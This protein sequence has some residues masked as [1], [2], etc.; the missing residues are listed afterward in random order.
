MDRHYRCRWVNFR[1]ASTLLRDRRQRRR[2]GGYR[3]VLHSRLAW[4]TCSLS[5]CYASYTK[6]MT[7]SAHSLGW[8]PI[9]TR[10]WRRCL[11]ATPTVV[12]VSR[13]K[14][15]RDASS[16]L[17]GRRT[18]RGWTP[19]RILGWLPALRFVSGGLRS[20]CSLH[21][22]LMRSRRR[23]PG[24]WTAPAQGRPL[25]ALRVCP[26]AAR[27]LRV[28]TGAGR[29]CPL[30]CGSGSIDSHPSPRPS[31]GRGR[32]ALCRHGARQEPRQAPHTASVGR[33]GAA[34]RPSPSGGLAA[35]LDTAARLEL[36]GASVAA[37]RT[38]PGGGAGFR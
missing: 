35:S 29:C 26:W 3:R 18:L 7:G 15:P 11:H 33:R 12:G 25:Q 10:H 13:R 20:L 22:N 36:S 8:T 23:E 16:V 4:H 14:P 9:V 34:S 24:A 38:A 32:V 2:P 5:S 28:S 19:R 17:R 21:P 30:S 27:P 37:R 31:Q 1:S 6:I